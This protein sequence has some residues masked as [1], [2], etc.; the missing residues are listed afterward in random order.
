MASVISI[1]NSSLIKLGAN[2][3][4]AL[5]ETSK[6][7]RLCNAQFETVR[8]RLLQSHPWNNAIKRIALSKLAEEPAFEYSAQFSLPA[9]YL[10]VLK[11]YPKVDY[12]I[13]G[14]RLLCN[15]DSISIRYI[16]KA[17]DPSKYTPRFAEALAYELG[18][19]LCYALIQ[20][21]SQQAQFVALADDYLSKA[22]SYDAQEGT[23]Q[24][25]FS[26]SW[27]DSRFIDD[28]I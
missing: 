20:S 4:T 22:R 14:D 16:H 18:K 9:D 11:V 28:T 7:A 10:R 23:P 27:N 1:C 12:V 15:T 3:I 5:T 24:Q 21:N 26:D 2:T 25:F 13:E 6:E 17:T 8:D 19:E